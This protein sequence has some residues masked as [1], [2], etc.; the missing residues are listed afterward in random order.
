MKNIIIDFH[1]HMINHDPL[2]YEMMDIIA[3]PAS[4]REE[5]AAYVRRHSDPD[6]FAD[7]IKSA[8]ADYC[9]VL[10]EYIPLS[11]GDI[12][13]KTVAEFCARRKEL[14]PFCSFNPHLHDRL[15][16]RLRA[17][18]RDYP[19]KGIKLLPSYN[20]F[21]PQT[22]KLYPLYE[23]AEELNLPVMLHTGS[24]VI[25]NTRI[26]Y[27][28]PLFLDDIASE[29]PDLKI[30]LSHGGRGPWYAEALTMIRLHKNV[31]IDLTGLPIRKLPQLFP[32]LE[33]FSHKF[34]FGTDWPQMIIK[35]SIAKFRQL[36]LAPEALQRILGQNAA[37]LLNLDP[38]V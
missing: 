30:V 14:I 5:F 26:K 2:A 10:A 37:R 25:A 7:M 3:E 33:R 21:Y 31:Y 38:G 22:N 32:D 20:H 29:F 6:F 23:A 12:S 27:A 1:V 17:L 35:D 24:S 13:N 28:N 11:Y 9:V 4:S 8:G 18:C 34:V 19:F 15:G 36:E 16:R